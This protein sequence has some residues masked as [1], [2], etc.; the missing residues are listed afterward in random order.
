MSG[1]LHAT[2]SQKL[3]THWQMQLSAVQNL[4]LNHLRYNLVVLQ[5][6]ELPKFLSH[7]PNAG[8]EGM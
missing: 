6:R 3:W 1:A 7:V 5:F 2:R 4:F 8:G